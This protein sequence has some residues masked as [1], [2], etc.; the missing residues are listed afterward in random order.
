[1]K[2]LKA[3]SIVEV[4][5][6][7]ALFGIIFLA[8]ISFMISVVDNNSI[9]EQR[10]DLQKSSIFVMNHLNNS[11]DLTNSINTDNSIF[12]NN[13]GKIVLNLTS[14]TVQYYV[15]N[16]VLHYVENGTDYILT[17]VDYNITKFYLER[18]LNGKDE[19]VGARFDIKFQ[20]V[21][22]SNNYFTL[23]TSLLFK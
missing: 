15:S 18:V 13:N 11:F 20:S 5:V 23:Q 1:M 4:L 8:I 10:I 17:T 14:G 9:A 7:F 3:I 12:N 19:L 2:K 16:N 22:T 21:K 6:Y